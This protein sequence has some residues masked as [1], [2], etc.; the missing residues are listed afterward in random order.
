M[1]A[2]LVEVF[3]HAGHVQGVS[4]AL[5][6]RAIG[7][8]MNGRFDEAEAALR[9]GVVATDRAAARAYLETNLGL[10]LLTRSLWEPKR[11]QESEQ[12]TGN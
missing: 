10:L 7:L 2:G 12:H 6:N 9:E 3:A 1:L 5:S 8:G 11:R 4:Y